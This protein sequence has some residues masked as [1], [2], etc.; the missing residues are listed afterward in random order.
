PPSSTFSRCSSSSD[1]RRSSAWS[2][3]RPSCTNPRIEDAAVAGDLHRLENAIKQSQKDHPPYFKYAFHNLY[4]YSVLGGFAATALLTQ[5]WWFGVLGA[6]L[7]ALW[8]VFAPDSKLLRRF[9]F[10]RVHGEKVKAQATAERGRLLASLPTQD[11]ERIIR[12]EHQ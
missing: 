12:V 3:N 6:G 10:D 11:A 9:W 1:R 5:N 7:E 8:M 4:N 2:K